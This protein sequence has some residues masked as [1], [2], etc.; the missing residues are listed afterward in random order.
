[1]SSWL[2]SA[3]EGSPSYRSSSVHLKS[4][5]GCS[6]AGPNPVLSASAVDASTASNWVSRAFNVVVYAAASA[7]VISRLSPIERTV[8]SSETIPPSAAACV[9]TERIWLRSAVRFVPPDRSATDI[10]SSRPTI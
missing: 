1:M 2:I 9:D 4:G 6:G 7:G 10:A 8:P 3:P 5:G